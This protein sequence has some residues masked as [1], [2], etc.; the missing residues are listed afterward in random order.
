MVIPFSNQFALSYED[1]A[2]CVISE[3]W[4]NQQGK[5]PSGL[6]LDG[7]LAAMKTI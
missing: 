5:S 7:L 6:D 4:L 2:Y 3:S 1:E